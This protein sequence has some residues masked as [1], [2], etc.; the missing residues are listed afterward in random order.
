M[1]PHK[2]ADTRDQLEAVGNGELRCNIIN[3]PTDRRVV[4]A[5]ETDLARFD[6]V[7]KVHKEGPPLRPIESLDG[8]QTYG[9]TKWLFRR[10]HF[11]TSDSDSTVCSST[12]FL[13][14]L[15]GAYF[16]FDGTIYEQVKGTPMGSPTSRF[17]AE[18]VLQRLD[19]L[20]FRHHKPTF[21]ARYVDDTFVVIKRDPV[22]TSKQRINADLPDIQFT[23]EEGENN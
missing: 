1:Q 3:R 5:Q 4:R 12:K 10:L 13:E 14:K 8:T 11:L 9:L 16:T 20:V 17:I 22:L 19:S 18:A 21:W 2:N 6:G 15:K 7:P 23:M